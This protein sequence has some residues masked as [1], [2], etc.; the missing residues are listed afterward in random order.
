MCYQFSNVPNQFFP[1]IIMKN[2][3]ELEIPNFNPPKCIVE[4]H[5][6]M[7]KTAQDVDFFLQ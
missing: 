1:I 3:Y 7:I 4:T 5:N 2:T 6:T